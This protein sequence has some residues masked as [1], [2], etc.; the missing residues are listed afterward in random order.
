M[1]R[2]STRLGA[3]LLAASCLAPCLS[4]AAVND[5]LFRRNAWLAAAGLESDEG[6]APATLNLPQGAR[7]VKDF[8]YGDDPA[9]RMDVYVPPHTGTAAVIFMV[10]GGAWAFGDKGAGNVVAAKSARWL[11]K[12]YVFISVNYRMVPKANPVEQARDVGKALATAQA[13]AAEWGADPT[14]F[15]LMGHSA[16]AHLVSLISADPS[17]AVN[18]G[19]KPWLGTVS[20]DSASMDVV[21][22]MEASQPRFLGKLYNNAF[23]SDRSFWREASPLHRLQQRPVPMLMVCSTRRDDSCP[24]AKAFAAK[25][26]SLGG[27]ATVLPQ[28]LSHAEINKTLGEPGPYTEA[29]EGFLRSLGLN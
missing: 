8:S 7:I 4:H 14:R 21:S 11:G 13:H 10:H 28:A 23:G 18:Q 17:I 27:R 15:V 1:F 12:G 3:A 2:P 29:V 20:L 6:G 24:Q 9:Q 19:A 22:T 5:F 26:E 25:V 16:G